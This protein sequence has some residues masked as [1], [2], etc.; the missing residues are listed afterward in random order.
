MGIAAGVRPPTM[1][2]MADCMATAEDVA[3]Q[4]N[5]LSNQFSGVTDVSR[6]ENGMFS[7]EGVVVSPGG[8]GQVDGERR[9]W[10]AIAMDQPGYTA[11][12][13]LERFESAPNAS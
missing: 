10:F 1:T 2:A 5:S 6:C 12:D 7:L 9:R 3:N 4:L 13:V 8:P 11:T